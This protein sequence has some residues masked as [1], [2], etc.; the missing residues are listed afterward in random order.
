M[1]ASD[2][3]FNIIDGVMSTVL[4]SIGSNTKAA[5][6]N[7][8]QY[9]L[10]FSL[11][12]NNISDLCI[13]YEK[14]GQVNEAGCDNIVYTPRCCAFLINSPASRTNVKIVQRRLWKAYLKTRTKKKTTS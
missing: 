3:L 8:A 9:S 2:E 14:A 10:I 12:P 11:S 13:L 6:I 7:V 5:I 1:E 4:E